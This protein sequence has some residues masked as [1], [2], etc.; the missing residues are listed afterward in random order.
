[1]GGVKLRYSGRFSLLPLPKY[2][3]SGMIPDLFNCGGFIGDAPGVHLK[4][5]L[6]HKIVY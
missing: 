5:A 4:Y 1:M 2:V 6:V 3:Y